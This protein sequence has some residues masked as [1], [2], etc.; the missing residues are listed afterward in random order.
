[1]KPS[2]EGMVIVEVY[3]VNTKFSVFY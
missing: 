2:T 1:M 3:T